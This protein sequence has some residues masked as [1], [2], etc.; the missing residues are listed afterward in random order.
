[1]STNTIELNKA[2]MLYMIPI[3]KIEMSIV[4]RVLTSHRQKCGLVALI[5]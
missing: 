2:N 4:R 5:F 3:P 1:M